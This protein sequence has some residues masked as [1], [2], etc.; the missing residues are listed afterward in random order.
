[1]SQSVNLVLKTTQISSDNTPANYY[2]TTVNSQYGSISQCRSS[3]TWKNINM[4]TLLGDMFDQYD[5]F[6]INLNF[7]AGAA[8]GLTAEAIADNRLFQIKLTG[9]PFTSSYNM[10]TI[11]NTGTVSLTVVQA[12]MTIN[13]T[14]IN[15]YFSQQYFTFTKQDL[16]NITIDLH[17]VVGDTF[18]TP[19]SMDRQIGHMIFSFNIYGVENFEK[20][21]ITSHR[22]DLHPLK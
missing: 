17:T 6:N 8:T 2:N 12:P 21:D 9:L 13:T 11:S 16:V 1:M 20:K 5:R 14:W 3:I 15:N 19:A 4:K 10:P 7:V 18:Y 22:F